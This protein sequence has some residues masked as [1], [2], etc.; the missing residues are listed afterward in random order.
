L[1]SY[2]AYIVENG[3]PDIYR[4]SIECGDQG[5]VKDEFMDEFGMSMQVENGAKNDWQHDISEVLF[6]LLSV[7]DSWNATEY[8]RV[9]GSQGAEG[10]GSGPPAQ[11][12]AAPLP[13][14]PLIPA[15][16]AG[17]HYVQEKGGMCLSLTRNA[18]GRDGNHLTIYNILS[19]SDCDGAMYPGNAWR[20]QQAHLG[21]SSPTLQSVAIS[22]KSGAATPTAL[23]TIGGACVDGTAI[24]ASNHGGGFRLASGQVLSVDCTG[25]CAAV[26]IPAA[27][28][29]LALQ[30]EVIMG[31]APCE[32]SELRFELVA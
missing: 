25:K 17:G 18:R 23:A 2:G 12:W 8:M 21:S 20:Q 4:F 24:I 7:V 32:S 6:P 15:L 10:A 14:M 5:C 30:N 28:S 27:G 13:A 16:P 31:L 9:R 3:T 11:P 1:R 26:L 22:R 29:V 19:L